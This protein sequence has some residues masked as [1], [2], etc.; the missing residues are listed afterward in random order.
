MLSVVPVFSTGGSVTLHIIDLWQYYVVH[1]LYVAQPVQ[2]VPLRVSRGALV[3]L[4]RLLATDPRSS[5]VLL[6]SSVSLWNDLVTLY[7]MVS[8]W[9]VSR[10]WPMS[11]I[12]LSCSLPF[13]LVLFSLSLL[14]MSWYFG[15]WGLLTNGCLALSDHF[16]WPTFSNDNYNNNNSCPHSVT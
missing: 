6:F 8:D 11:F 13:S 14:S 16:A 15:A 12:A 10:A 2:Y 1:P 3:A 9:L 5:A 4:V 7:L